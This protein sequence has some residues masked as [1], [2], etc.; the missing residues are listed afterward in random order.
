MSEN[1]IT[2]DSGSFRDPSGFIFYYNG[3]VYRAL[4][5]NSFDLI[6]QLDE[7]EILLDLI[8]GG[9]IV[10]TKVLSDKDPVKKELVD[11]V[12]DFHHFLRHEKIP[13]ITYPYEWPFSMLADATSQTLKLQRELIQHGYSLKDASA[14]NV[15]F[16]HT[17]PVL[18]DVTSIEVPAR[19]DVWIA[20]GQF[21]RLFLFPLLLHKYKHINTKGYYLADVD[22][23]SVDQVYRIFGKSALL[24]PS[25]FFHVFLQYYFQ[26]VGSKRTH[27]LKKILSKRSTNHQAQLFNLDRMLKLIFKISRRDK[28]IGPWIDYEKEHSYSQESE[29]D[30]ENFITDFLRKYSPQS[31][32]DLGSNTGKY[33]FIAADS[34]AE[35]IALDSDHESIN[36]VYE[37]AREKSAK[38]LPLWI[39][40]A[41]TSP[42]IGFENM[43]RRSFLDRVQSECVFALALLHHLLITSRIP[44][45]RIRDF[46]HKLTQKYL[47]IEFVDS[48]DEMFQKLLELREDIYSSVKFQKFCDVFQE[49]FNLL[50]LRHIRDSKR[51]LCLFERKDGSRVI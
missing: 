20:Y 32:L 42:S 45:P 39:D 21:C 33:S 8:R 15:Q 16:I 3:E 50:E 13:L 6:K 19:L 10:H 2:F 11:R 30:K 9:Y 7:K 26:K 31:V 4:D 27:E 35:V 5:D 38:I 37:Y 47:V 24:K 49:R 22:G 18:I 46:F 23:M 29:E 36:R 25:L 17:Q 44:L 40:I 43:E 28:S 12:P 51:T 1:G 14:Y 41:N 48:Q 34:G